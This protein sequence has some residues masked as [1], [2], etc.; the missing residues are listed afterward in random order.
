[1]AT[2][3]YTWIE[4]YQELADKLVPYKSKR[5]ELVTI[6]RNVFENSKMKLPK[7]DDSDAD[8]LDIDPFTLFGLF[9][10]A[11]KT[12]NRIAIAKEFAERL[13]VMS[14]VP[15]YFD[16]I[17]VVNMQAG[18]FYYFKKD[19]GANDI[20][21]L[22]EIFVAALDFADNPNSATRNAF[23]DIY[24]KVLQQK[25]VKWNITMGL[26]WI[27][28]DF[29]LN[30]DGRN[31]W[32]LDTKE[33]IDLGDVV[34]EKMNNALSGE[35]YLL[36][37]EKVKHHIE[38]GKTE[39]KSLPDFSLKAWI[40]SEEE[41]QKI[42]EANQKVPKDDKS[43]ESHSSSDVVKDSEGEYT[44]IRKTHYWVYAPGEK[45]SMWHQFYAGGIMGLGWH[46]LGDL[47]Q[48]ETKEEMRQEI[49]KQSD[50]STSAKNAALAN[51]E[52]ANEMQIGDVI[53]VKKGHKKYLGWGV[54][55]SEYYYDASKYSEYGS[56]RKVVWRAKGEWD[57]TEGTIVNKTL[58]DI[59]KYPD[60]VA[61]I[62]DILGINNK[63]NEEGPD[64]L[65]TYT[66]QDFLSEVYMEEKNYD[67]LVG[68]LKRKKNIVLQGA[69]GVGKTFAAKRLAYSIMGVV[70]KDRVQ[71]VQF[72]QNTSYEDFIMGYKPSEEGGFELREGVLYQFC[73]KAKFDHANDYFFIIDE[74]NR[75][76][77]SKIFGELLMLIEA[78][79]R[80]KETLRLSY[81]TKEDEEFTVPKNLHIIGMMNTADR[82]L[83]VIDYA[84]RRRFSFY[85]MQPAFKSETFIDYKKSVNNESFD[86][87]I[88]TIIALN[89]EITE[90][91]A[92]GEGFVIGHSYFCG[93]SSDD[94]DIKSHLQAVV[95]YDII[96]TIKEYWFDN[97]DKV[98]DWIEK[99]TKTV[100]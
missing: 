92:L 57:E 26:Y 1:M 59:T 73:M 71:F 45:A 66:K 13:N 87:L 80:G 96:P 67:T 55:T 48:Y 20:D 93:F 52:F 19:R 63:T 70:D 65:P 100:E 60:Y 84:L 10:K 6:V 56:Q 69:P 37:L 58:T 43:S 47:T 2:S 88:D 41:N 29:F 61:R 50:V 32:Y 44:T 89:K 46:E 74:I 68:L 9:N 34:Y 14:S 99:L 17:P 91:A 77:I 27:R 28:P 97:E 81:Q 36:L 79:K 42:R 18:T 7:L 24:D 98:K 3:K 21:N 38:S 72:H 40:R 4:F 85:T 90:D 11:L 75:G 62:F 53:I 31:R 25:G 51:W 35:D 8:F 82:S 78:D 30:L 39:I 86:N 23:K 5:R 94:N 64:A 12:E 15:E 33:F 54:V 49:V 16:G 83:A 22:W 76:N 95:N